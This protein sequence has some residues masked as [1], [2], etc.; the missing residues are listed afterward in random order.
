MNLHDNQI[1]NIDSLSGLTN[2]NYLYLSHNQICDFSPLDGLGSFY[3]ITKYNQDCDTDGVFDQYDSCPNEDST[4]FDA[5]GDGCIDSFL[6]L[7]DLLTS[8]VESGVIPESFSN[9]LFAKV[10]NAEKSLDKDVICSAVNGLNAL[11]NEINAQTGKK[12]STDAA[13][14]IINYATS[15]S[16]YLISSNELSCN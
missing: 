7:N 3:G 15:L 16:D 4:G 1:Q 6:G 14:E 10:S 12:I 8:L 9:S 5:D 13:T 11:I 2:L